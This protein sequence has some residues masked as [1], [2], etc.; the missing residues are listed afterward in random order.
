[1]QT[2]KKKTKK[3]EPIQVNTPVKKRKFL[4]LRMP[5]S[6]D[7]FLHAAMIILMLFGI[8]MV[9]SASMGVAGGNNRF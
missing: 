9:G 2:K 6:S 5:K 4:N 8:I 3:V 7:H 1:M